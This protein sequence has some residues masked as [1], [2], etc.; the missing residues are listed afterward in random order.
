MFVVFIPCCNKYH[1]YENAIVV[2]YLSKKKNTSQQDNIIELSIH[3]NNS[4]IP[5]I[6][7]VISTILRFLSYETIGRD[8]GAP[9]VWCDLLFRI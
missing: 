9:A 5:Q 7:V 3:N 1:F 2:D 6:N 8:T 4:N